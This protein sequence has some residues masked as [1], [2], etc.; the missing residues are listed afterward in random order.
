MKNLMFL[1]FIAVMF[2]VT[3]VAWSDGEVKAK[4]DQMK[5]N[6]ENSEKNKESY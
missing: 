6:V 4:L 2:F 1:V 5:L 3:R